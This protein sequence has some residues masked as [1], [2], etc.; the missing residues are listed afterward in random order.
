LSGCEA[1]APLI[2][3]AVSTDAA[4]WLGLYASAVSSAVAL[5]TLYGLVFMRIKVLARDAYAVKVTGTTR[6]MVVYGDDTLKT[7]GVPPGAA[8]PILAVTVMNRGR[9]PVRIDKVSRVVG[10]KHDVF[11]DFMAQVPFDLAPGHSESVV[12][13]RQG[14]HSHGDISL[15]RF[16]VVEGA[17]RIHPWTERWRQRVE[18]IVYWPKR[19]RRGL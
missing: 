1:H 5:V 17:G 11:G 6:E 16:Y 18:R 8:T 14:G 13:G 9:Q 10:V 3:A 19:P 15:R 4:F 7:M 2:V 12:H